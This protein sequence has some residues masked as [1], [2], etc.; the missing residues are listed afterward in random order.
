MLDLDIIYDE[1]EALEAEETTYETCEK[2]ASL[3][4]VRDALEKEESVTG[5]MLGS[6]FML[7]C[8]DVD[9]DQLMKIMDDH[10]SAIKIVC[11][12]E[13]ESVL[14]KIRAIR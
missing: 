9:L 7:A 12:K 11:P 8:S 5:P 4:I 1:I 10:M 14:K 2:L 3:Y 6:E 13:Y